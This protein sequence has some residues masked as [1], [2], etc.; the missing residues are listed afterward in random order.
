MKSPLSSLLVVVILTCL[1]APTTAFCKKKKKGKGAKNTTEQTEVIPPKPASNEAALPSPP[2]TVT[3]SPPP[4][5]SGNLTTISGKTYEAI[6]LKRVDPDGLLILHKGG[7]AKVL[8]TDLPGEM[9]TDYGYDAQKATAFQAEQN[10]AREA[11]ATARAEEAE[12][13]AKEQ[14]TA[15]EKQAD[16]K[17]KA[18]A[19]AK[20]KLEEFVV[21]TVLNDHEFI[22]HIRHDPSGVYWLVTKKA[23]NVAD[24]ELLTLRVAPTGNTRQR[25][26]RTYREVAEEGADL[27]AGAKKKK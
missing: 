19:P 12:R 13:Q 2:T 22:V 20:F 5:I 16:E 17:K 21:D 24:D 8:F 9:R 3:T 14:A 1:A 18:K 6:A 10:A 11:E 25:F 23:R 7:V 26:A 27:K 15:A 4:Q